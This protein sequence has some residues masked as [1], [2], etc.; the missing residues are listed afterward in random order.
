MPVEA[1]KVLETHAAQVREREIGFASAGWLR[2]GVRECGKQ[3]G[4]DRNRDGDHDAVLLLQKGYDALFH[5]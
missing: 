4:A 2:L 3:Q 1:E 5:S